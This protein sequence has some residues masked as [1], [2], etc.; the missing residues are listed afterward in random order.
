M[1]SKRHRRSE[2]RRRHCLRLRLPLDLTA[3]AT[4]TTTESQLQLS[5]ADFMPRVPREHLEATYTL[6]LSGLIQELD[7]AVAEQKVGQRQV[8]YRPATRL[9]AVHRIEALMAVCTQAAACY[10][11]QFLGVVDGIPMTFQF[12]DENLHR[13]GF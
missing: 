6:W 10:N 7:G 8:A 1:A 12:S 2:R 3:A 11:M 5:Q 13:H 9:V 4:T